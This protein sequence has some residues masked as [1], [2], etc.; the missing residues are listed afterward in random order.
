MIVEILSSSPLLS[1]SAD[2]SNNSSHFS[3][4]SDTAAHASFQSDSNEGTRTFRG[5]LATTRSNTWSFR[6]LIW[7]ILRHEGLTGLREIWHGFRSIRHGRA[8]PLLSPRS[9]RAR[10]KA[11]PGKPFRVAKGVTAARGILSVAFPQNPSLECYKPC[12]TKNVRSLP[13]H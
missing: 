9:T 8:G 6:G 12:W 3:G 10:L 5:I 11:G 2:R 13:S 4:E 7:W 1:R